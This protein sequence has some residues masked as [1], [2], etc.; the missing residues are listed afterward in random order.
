MVRAVVELEDKFRPEVIQFNRWEATVDGNPF[1]RSIGEN[2]I[3]PSVVWPASFKYRTTLIQ[4]RATSDED[5]GWCVVEVSKRFME[6]DEPFGR[7]P[8]VDSYAGGE[9]VVILTILSSRTRTSWTLVV[10]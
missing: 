6:M 10:C 8:E 2:Y 1:M 3:D 4:R 5:H 7:I 9:Q